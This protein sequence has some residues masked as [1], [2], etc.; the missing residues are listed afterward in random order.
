M[1][2][3]APGHSKIE[4]DVYG[5]AVASTG[6]ARRWRALSAES[7]KPAGATAKHAERQHGEN[8]TVRSRSIDT[9]E[10]CGEAAMAKESYSRLV[11]DFIFRGEKNG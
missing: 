1:R 5:E 9:C 3:L 2:E 11:T 10:A 7:T 8:V 4:A 6:A